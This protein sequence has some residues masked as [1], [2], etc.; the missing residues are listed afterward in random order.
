M[1]VPEA[2]IGLSL[3]DLYLK[4]EPIVMRARL[5]N[6]LE[7]AA[8]LTAKIEAVSGDR[9]PLNLDFAQQERDWVLAIDNLPAGLYRVTVQHSNADAALPV[10]GLFEVVPQA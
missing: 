4:D 6:M 5:I 9:S 3:D 8:A 1:R 2:A 7:S 10:H